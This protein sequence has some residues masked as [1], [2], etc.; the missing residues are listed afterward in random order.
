MKQ[1]DSAAHFSSSWG[2]VRT[3]AEGKQPEIRQELVL[4]LTSLQSD[5]F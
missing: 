2:A 4:L 1:A 3:A 5:E